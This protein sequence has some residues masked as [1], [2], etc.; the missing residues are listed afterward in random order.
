MSGR[1]IKIEITQTAKGWIKMNEL[2]VNKNLDQEGPSGGFSG[3]PEGEFDLIMDGKLST[4]FTL[5]QVDEE[6]G[7]LQYLIS[8][9][10]TYEKLSILQDPSAICGAEVQVQN[11]E[12]QWIT[13]GVLD[14]GVN[15][16]PTAGYGP[17]L[18]VRLNWAP[19]TAPTIAE[20]I[21]AEGG[22]AA[23]VPVGTAPLRFP[24]IYEADTTPLAISVP[25]GT[26]IDKVGL[27]FQA[28]V[29]LS[30]GNTVTIPVTWA[31]DDYDPETP[32]NYTFVGTYQ[33]DDSLTNPG[34]FTLTATV[35]VKPEAG[36]PAEPVTGNLALGCA[37]TVS[38]E[39]PGVSTSGSNLVD[40]N[41]GSRWSAWPKMK[42][43]T[44]PFLA[45]RSLMW[46]GR[47][48]I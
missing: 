42:E 47:Y 40:D 2:E 3:T 45:T 15:T 9:P 12:E 13:V 27:P 33:L 41:T 8:E 10:K 23:E 5:D 19:G 25:N 32:G 28:D 43:K 46:S 20:L 30:G 18:G 7:Y 4:F 29:V 16:F 31:C 44:I 1:Y 11:L 39:E 17:L 48:S 22:T 35:T 38:G 24:A 21:L 6:G 37:V 26:P 34:L 14:K 36:Q